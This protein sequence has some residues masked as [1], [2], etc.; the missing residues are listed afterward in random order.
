MSRSAHVDG[1][2]A[3]A[4]AGEISRRFFLRAFAGGVAA[5]SSAC[6]VTSSVGVPAAAASSELTRATA[7][8]LADL[9]RRKRV[10]SLEVVE[11]YLARIAQINPQLNA[12]VKLRADEARAEAR[13]AD[14]ALARGTRVGPLHGVPMTIKDSIDTAG[15]VTTGGTSG[16][17]G[18]VPAEDATVVRRLKEAG[19][20]LLGKSNTPEMTWSYETY[21]VVYGRTSN[22]YDLDL[23]P[24]GSSGGAGA[25]VAAGGSPFDVGSDTGGSI[26]VPA[27]L[28]G[29]AGLKPTS[30]RI[31]RTGHVVPAEGLLQSFTVLGPMA[32]S[33]DDLWL[34]FGILAGP[35]WRDASLI[36]APLGDPKSVRLRDLRVA[37]HTDNGIATPDAQVAQAVVD[38]AAALEAGGARV[39]PKKPDALSDVLAIDEDIFRADGGAWMKRLVDRAGTTEPGVEVAATIASEPMSSGELTAAVER[40]DAWR[41]R[42]LG[43]LEE[44]DAIV[45]PPC[46]VATLPHDAWV[47]RGVYAGFSYSFAYNMTGWPAVV[48][49]AGTSSRG[50]PI[51]VQIIGRPFRE[52][53]V[54]ALAGQIERELGGYRPPTI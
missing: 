18:F 22:P 23:S 35:D 10:S 26:R 45:C 20:I 54:L 12:V 46:A 53:V 9:I 5:L 40:L 38:A 52:D 17:T 36:P 42:M 49:R 4:L 16:R 7:V 44:F 30:G 41:G 13:A 3:A 47:E 34:L 32:R 15:V 11:A 51:G 37:M 24:G 27:H 50:T 2:G 31:S 14:Q 25:I 33:V 19:A 29:I 6:D 48:V 21:N 28:C 43:F 39:E 1:P 8:Q